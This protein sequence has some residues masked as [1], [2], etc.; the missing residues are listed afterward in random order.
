MTKPSSRANRN[1]MTTMAP[2]FS[3]SATARD[4][5]RG[6]DRAGD[7]PPAR[8]QGGAERVVVRIAPCADLPT[9]TPPRALLGE[10]DQMIEQW[11]AGRRVYAC[12]VEHGSE[13]TAAQRSQIRHRH[14]AD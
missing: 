7:R 12:G 5:R 2:S 8:E 4:L 13:P 3:P 14:D 10:G 6:L 11:S 1:R 9:A